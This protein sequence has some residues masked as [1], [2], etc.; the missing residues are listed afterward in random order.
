[1]ALVVKN[2]PAHARDLRDMKKKKKDM[3]SVGGWEIFSGG[4]DSNPFQYSCLGNP[5]DRGAWQ[6][7]VQGVTVRQA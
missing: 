4:G 7:T 5:M 3:S 6:V 1:M 2:L